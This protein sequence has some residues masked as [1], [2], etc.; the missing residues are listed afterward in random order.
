MA[1]RISQEIGR[2][3]VAELARRFGLINIPPHPAPPIALGAYEVTLL[4]LASAYQVFQQ[5]GK[6]APPYLIASIT[7]ARGDLI[8][9]RNPTPPDKVYDEAK[10]AQ[11][12]GMMQGVI[13]R[14]TGKKADIGRAAA[15]KTGTSQDYHDAWFVGFTP[16]VVAGVWLGD[17]RGRPMQRVAGGDLPA[18]AWKRFMLAAED[19]LPVRPFGASTP[20]PADDAPAEDARR[21]FYGALADQFDQTATGTAPLEA[22]RPDGE[23]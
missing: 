12:I 13:A 15:G 20:Q 8:Y 1:V 5:G 18:L 21:D 14:G 3:K 17:D 4:D 16:D 10:A 2:D 7:N 6:K 9:R 22:P 19:G 11:M 23:P